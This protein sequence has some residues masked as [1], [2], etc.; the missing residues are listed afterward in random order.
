MVLQ[1]LSWLSQSPS[2]ALWTGGRKSQGCSSP[3]SALQP[4]EEL[5]CRKEN[6][7]S[8]KP[9]LS[10]PAPATPLPS[11]DPA[12]QGAKMQ[13]GSLNHLVLAQT[14][15]PREAGDLVQSH[16][17]TQCRLGPELRLVPLRVLPICAELPSPG[18]EAL[19]LHSLGL[20]QWR[21]YLSFHSSPYNDQARATFQ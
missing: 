12:P 16:T 18:C 5:A 3:V 6:G 1:Q 9:A 19:G 15:R 21:R 2:Q 11:P 4:G 8:T 10:F 13:P 14:L 20:L 17:A 7:L